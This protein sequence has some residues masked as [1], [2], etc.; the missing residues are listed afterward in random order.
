MKARAGLF[1]TARRPGV[2]IAVVCALLTGACVG[3]PFESAKIDPA[4]P[5]AGEVARLARANSDFP[6]FSEIPPV[7]ADVRPV[8]LYGQAAR[9]ARSARADLEQR[10]APSSWTLQSTETF[11]SGARAAAGAEEALGDPRAT[12]AFAEDLRRRATPPQA[13][14]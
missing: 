2:G 5:V 4:S 10:T 14:R 9:E 7:P 3:N 1:V 6:S 13:G 11:A 8:R 12:E